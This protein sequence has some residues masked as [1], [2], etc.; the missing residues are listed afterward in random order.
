MFYSLIEN[1]HYSILLTENLETENYTYMLTF[2]TIGI[3]YDETGS[4]M[5]IYEHMSGL[6]GYSVLRKSYFHAWILYIL[7]RK[8]KPR[9]HVFFRI[10]F[11]AIFKYVFMIRIS[12]LFSCFEDIFPLFSPAVL[13]H[14]LHRLSMEYVF[15]KKILILSK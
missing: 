2:T 8:K 12:L 9:I 5:V 13:F 11:P 10:S 4:H 3:F 1:T 6:F 14:I 15:E 7:S